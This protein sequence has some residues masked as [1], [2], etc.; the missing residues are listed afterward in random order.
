M[1]TASKL[2]FATSCLFAGG[3]FVYINVSQ[4][5]ERQNLRQGPIKDAERMR[6]KLS[7]KQ[8][9]N[10]LEHKEQEALRQQYEALQPLNAEIIRGEEE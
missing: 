6:L 10:D 3:A 7:K 2:T 5:M 1:S 4:K 9:A 8:L